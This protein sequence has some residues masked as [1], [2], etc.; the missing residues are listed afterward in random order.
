LKEA[1]AMPWKSSAAAIIALGTLA[2]ACAGP[3]PGI[4]GN[5]TG[6]IIPWSPMNH[7]MAAE[8]AAL[9][10]AGYNKRA[11]ITSIRAQYGDYIAF[12]CSWR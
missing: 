11:R 10:C 8:L 2:S 12:A 3:G 6:G 7:Q 4:T 5:D 9:H 1:G